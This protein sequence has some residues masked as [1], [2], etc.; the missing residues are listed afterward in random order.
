MKKKRLLEQIESYEQKSAELINDI[1]T[2]NVE[3]ESLE[4]EYEKT[5]IALKGEQGAARKQ[6]ETLS[7]TVRKLRDSRD[8]KQRQVDALKLEIEALERDTKKKKIFNDELNDEVKNAELLVAEKK[9]KIVEL[10]ET[11]NTFKENFRIL[12]KAVAF[13]ENV[14]AVLESE[15]AALKKEKNSLMDSPTISETSQSGESTPLSI[16]PGKKK[17]VAKKLNLGVESPGT[18]GLIRAMQIMKSSKRKRS[19]GDDETQLLQS[20]EDKQD[21]MDASMEDIDAEVASVNELLMDGYT[22]LDQPWRKNHAQALENKLM[23]LKQP[24]IVTG[25]PTD[26]TSFFS[27]VGRKLQK[28]PE[29]IRDD[30]FKWLKEHQTVVE[31]RN[32][33]NLSVC[34]TY[35]MFLLQGEKCFFSSSMELFLPSDSERERETVDREKDDMTP[36]SR[37][38]FAKFSSA[39]ADASKI[40]RVYE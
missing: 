5:R 7:G 25:K 30:I 13:D 12:E 26:D 24:Y 34:K 9:K 21:D 40:P 35:C 32:D 27:V 19:T 15:I 20:P 2:K 14:K 11:G 6:V 16:T 4:S 28:E 8:V 17:T 39:S 33:V 3:Y 10:A 37:S 22:F 29:E 1:G 38:I 23:A 36:V 18:T 31:V